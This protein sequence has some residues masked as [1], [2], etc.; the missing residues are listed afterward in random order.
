MKGSSRNARA[1]LRPR[2]VWF[3]TS[4]MPSPPDQLQ[5]GRHRHVDERVAGDLPEDG[6]VGQ[7]DEVGEA[8]EDARGGHP[9]I[10][11]A[12]EDAVE[13]RI[14]DE[15]EQEE[16]ARGQHQ[17]AEDALALEE[18]C[19]ART[20]GP[21]PGGPRE[22]RRPDGHRRLLRFVDLLQ[23]GRGRGDDVLGRSRRGRPWRTCRPSR[24]WPRSPSIAWL[25]R[26][27]PPVQPRG[28]ER[29]LVR[30][31]ARLGVPHRV[32][33]V[34]LQE[35][36]VVRV[37]R[38]EPARDLLVVV[39][40]AQERLGAAGTSGACVRSAWDCALNSGSAPSGPAD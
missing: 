22:R 33:V 29:L 39:E 19:A 20:A 1:R 32:V 17:P 37:G 4:A 27:G 36:R 16:D 28:L 5:D 3:M 25:G 11:Q 34:A 35:R 8:D 18:R 30:H 14:G 9:P 10:L 12:Q 7:R 38:D 13:E 15:R 21:R 2:N 40:P 23:L 26:A 24:T 31:V 6:V